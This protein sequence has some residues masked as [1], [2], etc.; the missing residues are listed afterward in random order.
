MYHGMKRQYLYDKRRRNYETNKEIFRG[1]SRHLIFALPTMCKLNN[2]NDGIYPK[3]NKSTVSLKAGSSTTLKVIN[4]KNVK[5]STSNSKV[6]KIVSKTSKT[7]KI[8]GLKF[9]K[10]TI[11]AKIGKK[12]LLCR[13][14]VKKKGSSNEE[15]CR[16]DLFLGQGGG[17]KGTSS[18]YVS[19]GETNT[20]DIGTL[21]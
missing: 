4:G 13:V 5:W 11:T 14:T 10:A 6:A 21:T 16:I 8:K 2:T 1:S 20:V 19:D 18:G 3:L 17:L 12:K 9:G 15:E 7:A